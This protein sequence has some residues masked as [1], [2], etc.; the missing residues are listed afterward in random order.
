MV[1]QLFTKKLLRVTF[2]TQKLHLCK[3]LILTLPIVLLDLTKQLDSFQLKYIGA[4]RFSTTNAFY[5]I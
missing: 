2:L 5:T 4:L 3:L 1:R